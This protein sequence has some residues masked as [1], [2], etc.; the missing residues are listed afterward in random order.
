[1]T[2][3]E[4]ESALITGDVDSINVKSSL[5][6]LL[7]ENHSTINGLRFKY[8][9]SFNELSKKISHLDMPDINKKN[10]T[11]YF[12]IIGDQVK[13]KDKKLFLKYAHLLNLGELGT[14]HWRSLR[15]LDDDI[16][17]IKKL[18]SVIKSGYGNHELLF[19]VCFLSYASK[20]EIKNLLSRNEISNLIKID[21]KRSYKWTEISGH[22]L[23]KPFFNKK[24]ILCET[25]K[26]IKSK[27]RVAVLI[28]G[29]MRGYKEALPDVVNKLIK[30]LDADVFLSTW[31]Q[32]GYREPS[33][34]ESE[35]IFDGEFL[36]TWKEVLINYSLK[37]L[38]KLY[39]HTFDYLE[40]LG[41]VDKYD[42][43]KLISPKNSIYDDA[44]DSEFYNWSGSKC[45]HY[46]MK[47]AFSLSKEHSHYDVYIRLRP[48]KKITGI[49][50]EKLNALIQS[51]GENDILFRSGVNTGP[52]GIAICDQFSLGGYNAMQAYHNI[53]DNELFFTENQ[54]PGNLYQP[55]FSQAF[56]LF[57]NKFNWS[58][59]D[60]TLEFGDLISIK[61]DLNLLKEKIIMDSKGR[62]LKID[63]QLLE[64]LN[65]DI[66]MK[67][68]KS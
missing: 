9:R 35:R 14:I 44:S 64:S 12:I 65:F 57:F 66:R 60:G 55:H 8:T 31:L 41:T 49:N 63:A 37:E 56:M 34:L 30:P 32:S 29:Q 27:K 62:E 38:K 18:V 24:N 33:S 40:S 5:E 25:Q 46:K 26:N 6:N 1:M 36:V 13:N 54:L 10:I 47:S 3:K 7:V 53:Y 52:F 28:S 19:F 21:S 48:D 51:V 45:M 15:F 20:F 59:I 39:V 4:I 58:S 11:N 61:P 42:I 43:Q 17:I 16:D 22:Y 23:D 68:G 67:S 50:I 2:I